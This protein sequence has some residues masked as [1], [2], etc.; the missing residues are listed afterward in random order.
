MK[1]IKHKIDFLTHL[2]KLSIVF[3][4]GSSLS[5]FAYADDHKLYPG[6]FCKAISGNFT[7]DNATYGSGSIANTSLDHGLS[8]RCPIIRDYMS[9]DTGIKRVRVWFKNN[10]TEKS[11]SCFLSTRYDNGRYKKL[12]VGRSA[13]GARQGSF[14]VEYGGNAGVNSFYTLKCDLPASTETFRS[15]RIDGFKVE[16]FN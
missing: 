1:H 10:N 13:I 7:L 9:E 3:L 2:P 11:I 5:N 8:I 14:T 4:L 15:P 12:R 6:S 16:E